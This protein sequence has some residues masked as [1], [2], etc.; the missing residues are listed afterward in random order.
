MLPL[1]TVYITH[2]THKFKVC[3]Y[4]CMHVHGISRSVQFS[5]AGCVR[6]GMVKAIRTLCRLCLLGGAA[7]TLPHF[8][9]IIPNI[10]V[11][12]GAPMS[13][14]LIKNAMSCQLWM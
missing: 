5:Q 6:S 14:S 12:S 7:G 8:I 3:M 2:C 10:L 11:E 13:G 4:V 9:T 1:V